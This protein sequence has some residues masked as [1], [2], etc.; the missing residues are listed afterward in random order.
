MHQVSTDVS[1]YPYQHEAG[2]EAIESVSLLDDFQGQQSL[3]L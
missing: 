2:A 3:L 1:L